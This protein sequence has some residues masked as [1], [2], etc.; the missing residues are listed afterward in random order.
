MK[1][2]RSYHCPSWREVADQ[3][4]QDLGAKAKTS[5]KDW[6]RQRGSHITPCERRSLKEKPLD[7]LEVG[8]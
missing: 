1:K 7:S 4:P 6:K 2:H 3:I 5:K 8:I